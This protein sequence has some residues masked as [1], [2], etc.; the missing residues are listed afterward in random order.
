MSRFVAGALGVIWAG[1]GMAGLVL[2]YD[3]DRWLIAVPAL[4]ALAYAVLWFRVTAC[5]RLLRWSD[6]V[7]PWRAR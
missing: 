5:A 4:F 3:Y 7:A 6:I 2:A 1:A